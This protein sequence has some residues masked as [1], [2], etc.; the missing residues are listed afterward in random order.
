MLPGL[1]ARLSGVDQ[2]THDTAEAAL[3]G[4]AEERDVKAGLLINAARTAMTGQSVGPGLFD[5][6]AILGR[7]RTAAR[8]RQAA[9]LVASNP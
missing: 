6:M 4:Y 5:I 1:A 9:G 7:E 2:F 8:L 3:R